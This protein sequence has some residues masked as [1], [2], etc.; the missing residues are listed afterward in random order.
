VLLGVCDCQGTSSTVGSSRV[1]SLTSTFDITASGSYRTKPEPRK[2][3]LILLSVIAARKAAIKH[4]GRTTLRFLADGITKP[5]QFL[6]T[7]PIV[8]L[9]AIYI[10]FVFDLLYLLLTNVRGVFKDTYNWNPEVCGLAYLGLGFGFGFAIGARCSC[11]H[12]RRNCNTT[13][14]GEWRRIQARNA[15]GFMHHL[16]IFRPY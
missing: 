14:Q 3:P 16:C 1:R 10:A 15:T 2:P 5:L 8:P 9:L 12:L 13:H 6:F 11:A 4:R 7:S